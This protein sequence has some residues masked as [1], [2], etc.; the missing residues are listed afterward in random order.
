[1]MQKG[2]PKKKKLWP[3]LTYWWKSHAPN[4]WTNISAKI[5]TKHP[6]CITT[7]ANKLSGTHGYTV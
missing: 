5:W 4:I 1:M 2:C 7:W 3:N 6:K